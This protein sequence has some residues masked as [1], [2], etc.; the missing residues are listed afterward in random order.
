VTPDDVVTRLKVV[1]AAATTRLRRLGRQHTHAIRHGWEGRLRGLAPATGDP[2]EPLAE[3]ASGLPGTS[4]R[5]FRLG[6]V[7]VSLSMVSA[8]ATYLILSNLAPIA[9][10]D[11]VVLYALFTNLVLVI[12]M[13]GV[14]AYQGAGLWRAW[15]RKVAGARLHVRIVALFSL[16]AAL[17]ALLLALAATSTFSRSLDSWFN[18]KTISIVRDATNIGKKYLEE[19]GPLIRTDAINMARD[20]DEAAAQVGTNAEK[21]R[22]LMIGQ[23]A[24]RDLPAAYL[25]DGA[26][27]VKLAVLEDQRI[28]YVRPPE[29]LIWAADKGHVPLLMPTKTEG[30]DDSN[31]PYQELPAYLERDAQRG[32]VAAV[33]KLQNYQ[34][35]Y[36]YVSRGVDPAV[37][38]NLRQLKESMEAYVQLKGARSGQVLAHALMYFMISL[39]ALF[40]AIWIGLWFAGLFV[41]PIRR[42]IGAAQEVARGNLKVELPIRRGEGDLRRLSA[43]FNA[44][45]K[46]LES[47][48]TALVTTNRQLSERRRFMEAVLSGVSAGVIGLDR[49]GRVTLVSRSA[50]KLLGRDGD[51]M[52]GRPLADAVPEFAVLVHQA[53]DPAARSRRQ[54]QIALLIDGE[55]R[56]FSVRVTEQ[57]PSEED[58]GS[59]VTFDDI[60]ELVS[61]QRTSA[62]ADVARRI[63]H[64]IKN[65]LTP[66]QLSA[67]RLR[68]KYAAA[69]TEDKET[70]D[71]CTETIIRQVG[72]VTRMVDEFSAFARSPKPQMEDHDIRDVVKAAVIDRQMASQDIAF[73]TRVGKDPIIVT[74]DR[75]LISQAVINLV[76]NAQEAIQQY[77][78]R[79]E[80][81]PGW[82]GRIETNL[83]RNGTRVEIEVID[84]G[85]GLPKQNRIRL[86]EPYVTTKGAKGTGLGLAIVQKSVEQHAGVLSLEDAPPAPGR[87]HGALIRISLPAHPADAARPSAPAAAVAGSA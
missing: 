11:E 1:A 81:E 22:E 40:A 18:E 42:L 38:R 72:D 12:A 60:T 67:E 46:E 64:E 52:V 49:D 21:F 56:S 16:I 54:Q 27:T 79:K 34:D 23:A 82:A 63:A 26:G 68:R 10:S 3:D 31:I 69:I 58:H 65:P 2:L 59:V 9:P 20:L 37:V 15:R 45:T 66:I 33:I 55:E 53:G 24:L 19:H 85:P 4:D 47:Q 41:A 87:T 62:W 5:A 75:R 7:V 8:L 73:D 25:I 48:R 36:L 61:A 71:R 39:T 51:A 29:G 86:T 43:N 83:R 57:A 28:P 30:L 17:P 77:A 35:S 70:F 74:C 44:M 80:K 50:E 32:R 78:E 6:L 13:V 76:K 84:N 14:I